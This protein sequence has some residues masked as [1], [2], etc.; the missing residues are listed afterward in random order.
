[1]TSVELFKTWVNKRSPKPSVTY[2]NAGI[3]LVSN[4]EI[5]KDSSLIEKWIK[6]S[7]LPHSR[8]RHALKLVL[9]WAA[10]MNI[11][12]S[13]MPEIKAR[14]LFSV[15]QLALLEKRSNQ[16]INRRQHFVMALLYSC[17]SIPPGRIPMIVTSHVKLKGSLHVLL[18]GISY[19]IKKEAIAPLKSWITLRLKLAQYEKECR[20]YCKTEAWA[21][22]EYLFPNHQGLMAD[23]SCIL[24]LLRSMSL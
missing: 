2:I 21:K 5:I 8:A 19:P 15:Q 4:F 20:F 13:I 9:Q 16:T 12:C 14:P 1:M 3:S 7:S 10:S 23:R 11:P 18:D 24:K 6:E 17:T 22:S